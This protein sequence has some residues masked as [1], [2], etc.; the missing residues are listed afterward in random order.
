MSTGIFDVL[1]LSCISV[2][3]LKNESRGAGCNRMI[4][5]LT[6]GGTEY[7]EEV[8]EKYNPKGNKVNTNKHKK[9]AY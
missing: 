8:F 2:F 1:W 4:M 6:D 5:L 7:A 3:Q 9:M